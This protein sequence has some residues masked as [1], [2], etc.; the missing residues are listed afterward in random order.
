MRTIPTNALLDLNGKSP[1]DSRWH[2]LLEKFLCKVA[3]RQSH[4]LNNIFNSLHTRDTE[5]RL[6]FGSL[7]DAFFSN[8]SLF[9]QID[10]FQLPGYLGFPYLVRLFIPSIDTDSDFCI[11][12]SNNNSA[13]TAFNAM[14]HRL[15]FNTPLYIDGS[16]IDE[17]DSS[18]VGFADYSL[19]I[20]T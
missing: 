4:P 13:E 12:D 2:F 8:K 9:E 10:H 5:E 19:Q 15:S 18:K 3:A 17:S 1:L 16:K 20:P 11:K 14:L 7:T 6:A